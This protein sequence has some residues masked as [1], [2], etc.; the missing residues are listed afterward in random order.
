MYDKPACFIWLTIKN[1]KKTVKY[2]ITNKKEKTER[3]AWR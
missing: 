2:E 1:F 3:G